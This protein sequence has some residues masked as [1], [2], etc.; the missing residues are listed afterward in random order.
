M[1]R[2]LATAAFAL[3]AG[4]GYVGPP[5]PP[6]L[7]MPQPIADLHVAQIGDKIIV[8]F[9]PPSLTTEDL[10]VTELRGITLYVG[11]GEAEFARDRW[12]ATAQRFQIAV[13]R[14]EF[15]IP[16][17]EWV[18]QQVILSVRTTGRTGRES[19]WSNYSYLTVAAPLAKPGAITFTPMPDAV[20]LKWTGNAPR[21]RV[22]RSVL[23]EAT[24]K[25]EPIGETEAREYVDQATAYGTRYQYV[26]LGLAGPDQQSLP[27]EPA[28]IT[29]TD[30]FAPAMPAGLSAVAGGRT[31]DLSWSR[32]TE[33]DLDGYN[34]FRAVDAGPFEA[35]AQ[36]VPL[37]AY[38]DTRV[39]AGKRYRYKV[40]AADKAGNE[41]ERSAEASAQ[42]E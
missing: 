33:D 37:P 1:S 14:N 40:S 39:E 4:C 9:T 20:A 19:D 25:L 13:T 38:T 21:Y 27:S 2:L 32:N 34:L 41:S 36:R 16:A 6:A 30:V 8:G 11:P 23:S 3:L 10:P 29:P 17:S 24:P 31:I 22:L 18:G 26:I 5:L 15:E 7:N 42:V 35:W 28:V 12:A